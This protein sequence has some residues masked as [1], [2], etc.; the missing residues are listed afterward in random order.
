MKP[1]TRWHW[2][3]PPVPNG[4]VAEWITVRLA[5]SGITVVSGLA[6][7]VDT[8]VH[9]ASLEGSGRTLAVLECGVDRIYPPQN[10]G[11]AERVIANGA[12]IRDYAP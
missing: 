10:R 1:A 6:S 5:N 8:N 11:L 9:Q 4:S 3:E 2:N 7:G 12:L